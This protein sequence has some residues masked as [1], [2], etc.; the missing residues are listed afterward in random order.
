[1]NREMSSAAARAGMV[2]ELQRTIAGLPDAIGAA[3]SAIPREDFLP[4]EIPVELAYAD[5]PVTLA[6]GDDG[7]PLSTASQPTMVAAMLEQL[8][9]EPG[10]RIL[11]IGTASGYN[12]ALLQHLVGAEGQV[13]SIEIDPTLAAAA[14]T[15][16]RALGLPVSVHVGDGWDGLS[17]AA[18]FDRIIATVGVF[19]LSPR[20]LDQLREGGTLVAPLWLRPGIELSVRFSKTDGVLVG[21]SAVHCAFLRLRGEHAGP[22]SYRSITDT[23]FATCESLSAERLGI[24]RMLLT[25]TPTTE[26]LPTLSQHWFATLALHDPRAIQVFTLADPVDISFGL[27][28]AD[29]HSLVLLG[30]DGLRSYGG[31]AARNELDTALAQLHPVDPAQLTITATPVAQLKSPALDQDS[32]VTIVRRHFRYTVEDR[33]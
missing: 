32:A 24:L 15:R 27:L 25:T 5:K 16:L 9:V 29:Q 11:E 6:V 14:E 4:A 2:A 26:P 31:P 10:D 7:F 30:G 18:P 1:M 17:S 20:W 28:D 12:A 19:D 23:H 3:L 33:R 22:D 13:H 8:A 21:R